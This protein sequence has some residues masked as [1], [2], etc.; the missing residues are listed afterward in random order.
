MNMV[1]VNFPGG[2]PVAETPSVPTSPPITVGPVLVMEAIPNAPNV[3]ATP[4]SSFACR[5]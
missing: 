4:K 5:Y 3:D 2:K 1:P